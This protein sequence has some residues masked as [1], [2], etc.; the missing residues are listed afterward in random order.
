MQHDDRHYYEGRAE[1]ELEQAQQSSNP[2]AVRAH[3]Q[4]AGLYLDKVF[5]QPPAEHVPER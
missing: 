3:Y 4:L 5:G 1:E 2:K